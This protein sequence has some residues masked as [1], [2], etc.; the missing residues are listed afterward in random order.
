MEL[1]QDP[2]NIHPAFL[3]NSLGLGI[4]KSG[5][6]DDDDKFSSIFILHEKLPVL[7]EMIVLWEQNCKFCGNLNIKYHKILRQKDRDNRKYLAKICGVCSLT[8]QSQ[9]FGDNR[10]DD[11]SL[12]QA[13]QRV[14]TGYSLNCP[15]IE[16]NKESNNRVMCQINFVINCVFNH[17]LVE[18]S[19]LASTAG[20]NFFFAE[21][22]PSRS[23]IIFPVE[24]NFCHFTIVFLTCLT[25]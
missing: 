23:I 18:R 13:V 22:L 24:A 10:P 16:S 1:F 2:V 5:M 14:E 17:G 12:C 21:F 20:G 11:I 3:K 15:E 7:L 6:R 8:L 19:S 4:I 9:R 25:I